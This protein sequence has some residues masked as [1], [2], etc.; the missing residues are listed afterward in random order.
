MDFSPEEER[1]GIHSSINLHTKRVVAAFYSIIECAQLEATQD[2]LLRTEIDN[3]QL[4]LHNDSLLHSCRSLYT[5]ASDLVINELLH[6][7]EPKL[8]KRVKDETDIARTLAVL[9]KR[10]SDFEN[11]LSVNDRGPRITELPRR[12]DA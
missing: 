1:A 12:K 3:F 2:C 7:P 6:S 5:I 4:K 10:I 8:R 11:V 9:R